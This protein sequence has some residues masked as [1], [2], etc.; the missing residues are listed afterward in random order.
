MKAREVRSAIVPLKGFA[1]D[2]LRYVKVA[3]EAVRLEDDTQAITTRLAD[4]HAQLDAGKKELARV[5]AEAATLTADLAAE[6]EAAR[7]AWQAEADERN[8]SL[9]TVLAHHQSQ[10]AH[11]VAQED[12]AKARFAR[13]GQR[14]E[15]DEATVRARIQELRE[16]AQRMARAG[17]AA[18]R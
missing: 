18:L 15:Q 6:R 14:L 12:E 13:T 16:L 5:K 7:H 9:A 2:V 4:L 17:E 10:I 1:E 11:W 3:D 8:A